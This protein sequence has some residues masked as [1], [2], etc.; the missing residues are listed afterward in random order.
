MAGDKAGW[1]EPPVGPLGLRAAS[2]CTPHIYT[3]ILA[4]GPQSWH[5]GAILQRSKQAG[6]GALTLA[7][8]AQPGLTPG[9]GSGTL[10]ELPIP[11]RPPQGVLGAGCWPGRLRH[12]T[13]DLAL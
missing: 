4:A 13:A 9:C 6:S 1:A 2:S 10:E 12:S 5:S 8:P 7:T 11:P 3:P